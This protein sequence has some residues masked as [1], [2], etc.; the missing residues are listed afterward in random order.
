MDE[1]SFNILNLISE[2]PGLTQRDLA[3]KTGFSIG[4]VNLVLKRLASTG[5]IKIKNLNKKKIYYLLT[6]KGFL[7]QSRRS[8]KYLSKTIR[9]F[10][11]YQAAVSDLVDSLFQDKKSRVAIIGRNEISELLEVVIKN[12]GYSL[13]YRFI[14]E[15]EKIESD[16]LLLDCRAQIKGNPKQYG[17][18]I[19]E[20]LLHK[21]NGHVMNKI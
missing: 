21:K 10:F 15:R 6:P 4:L 1:K 18:R 11:D 16:E 12:K 8:Y 17:V 3:K 19:L 7:E 9:V 5:H 14:E 20:E 2:F 13:K